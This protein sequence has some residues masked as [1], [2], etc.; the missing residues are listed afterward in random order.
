MKM[1]KTLKD[2]INQ[3]ALE[4]AYTERA[5]KRER[6]EAASQALERAEQVTAT[7]RE[8]VE[9]AQAKVNAD[10]AK[11]ARRLE[12]SIIGNGVVAEPTGADET[13]AVDLV[14][15]QTAFAIANR[16]LAAVRDTH[17]QRNAEAQAAEA[18]VIA[19][20]DA[21]IDDETVAIASRINR[22]MAELD[23]LGDQ[24]RARIPNRQAEVQTLGPEISKA[25]NS[26]PP[27][28]FLNT[29][30]NVIRDGRPEIRN[31]LAARR[32]KLIN[33]DIA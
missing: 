16:A 31:A 20:A 8:L 5:L 25:F 4:A 10:E 33:G 1:E 21:I 24:L 28:D 22:M 30:I 27:Q 18:A 11:Q 17:Q 15:S 14:R 32:S 7:A 6:L 3:A 26:L 19:A 12:A 23:E 9:Q 13:L 2:A 29:P